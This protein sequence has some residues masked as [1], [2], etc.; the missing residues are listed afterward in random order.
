MFQGGIWIF[1]VKAAKAPWGLCTERNSED[2]LQERLPT[3]YF[4]FKENSGLG[5]I[6]CSGTILKCTSLH[7]FKYSN[8]YI[9]IELV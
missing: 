7:H 3:M 4:F 9:K 5:M 1:Y 8:V 6:V 2:I